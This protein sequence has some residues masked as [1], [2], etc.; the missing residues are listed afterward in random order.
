MHF[1]YD[2]VKMFELIPKLLSIV[3]VVIWD[4]TEVWEVRCT[5]LP[6]YSITSD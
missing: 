3:T 6:H 2:C 1:M 4:V 5:R